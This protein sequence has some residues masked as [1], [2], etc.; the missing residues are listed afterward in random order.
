MSNRTKAV[1]LM[2]LSSLSFAVMAFFVKLSG[3]LPL[4]QKVF[5]RD[6]VVV[7]FVLCGLASLKVSPWGNKEN[8][9]RLLFRGVSGFIGVA[10]YFYSASRMYLS[11]STIINKLSPF[12]TTLF[13]VLLLKEKIKPLQII[14]L[15]LSL[16][17]GALVVKPE[18]SM[19]V[20]PALCG[21]I[22]AVVAGFSYA[23]VISL[24]NREEPLVVVF[25]FSNTSV[26]FSFFL[27]LPNFQMPT[28]QNL[29]ILLGTGIFAAGGQILLT[30]AYKYA[31]ASSV[32]VYSYSIIIFSGILGFIFLHEVPDLL[33]V[34]GGLLI[35]ISGFAL[36]AAQYVKKGNG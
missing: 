18:F 8:R 10:F 13:A 19:T 16:V 36:Y 15:I 2:L 23:M 35:I 5:F 25:Y 14:A 29:L 21:V 12:F 6:L 27:M 22:G 9:M 17:G 1:L 4:F 28:L 32:S 3:E 24:S 7:I 33:S 31:K 20:V 30:Y 11:D 26:L 34:I